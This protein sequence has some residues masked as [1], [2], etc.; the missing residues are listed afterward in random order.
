MKIHHV[1]P[2]VLKEKPGESSVLR[3]IYRVCASKLKESL[4]NKKVAAME[5]QQKP[6]GLSQESLLAVARQWRKLHPLGTRDEERSSP[7]AVEERI[8]R[9]KE[10]GAVYQDVIAEVG[11]LLSVEGLAELIAIFSIGRDSEPAEELNELVAHWRRELATSLTFDREIAHFVEKTNFLAC[12]RE[13]LAR[14]GRGEI[15]RSLEHI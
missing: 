7:L 15:A 12:V 6:I 11:K 8:T 4:T 3:I 5:A 9:T 10:Q 1:K 14:V 2:L 13:G